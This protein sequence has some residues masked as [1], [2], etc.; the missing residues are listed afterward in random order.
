MIQTIKAWHGFIESR[1]PAHLDAL[2]SDEVVFHS[3]VVHKPQ[4][5]KA[6][7]RMYLSA[8]VAV[9][10]NESF[11]YLRE[12]VSEKNAALEFACVIDGI[13]ING[14]DLIQWG[15]DGLITDFKVMVR[16]LKAINKLHELMAARLEKFMQGQ[17]QQ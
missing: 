15:E 16:P 14:V 7:S 1:D 11:R 10:G 6:I 5:G 9:L 13:E 2:L 17:A 8:A 3:P 4:Q 12:I